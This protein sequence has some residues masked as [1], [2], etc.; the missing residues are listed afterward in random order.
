MNRNQNV[1]EWHNAIIK[2]KTHLKIVFKG[3]IQSNLFEIE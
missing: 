3:S 1:N 2:I